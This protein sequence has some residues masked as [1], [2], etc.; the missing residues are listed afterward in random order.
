MKLNICL[1]I[2]VISDDANANSDIM[3]EQVDMAQVETGPNESEELFSVCKNTTMVDNH[4]RID[5]NTSESK[6]YSSFVF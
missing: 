1:F 3:S 5:R 2:N 4:S 6:N